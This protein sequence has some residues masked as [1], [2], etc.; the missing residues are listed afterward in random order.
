MTIEILR[1]KISNHEKAIEQSENI[2][3]TDSCPE[4][5]STKNACDYQVWGESNANKKDADR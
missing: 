4:T 5:N 3:D 2:N 1:K